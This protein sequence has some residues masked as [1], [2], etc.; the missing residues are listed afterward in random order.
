M[1]ETDW[2]R[3]WIIRLIDMLQQR[4]RGQQV[5]V[6]GDLL[7]Y[8]EEGNPKR[9]L[10]PD[11]FVVL[12]HQPGMRRIYKLWEEGKSPNA[13]IE[14]TSRRTKREDANAKPQK[15][16]AIGVGEYFLFDPTNDYLR[17][18][19]RGYRLT[20][21]GY[22]PIEPDATGGLI[23]EQLS[24]RLCLEAGV[25]VVRDLATGEPLLT[26]AGAERAALEAKD[27]VLEAE[28]AALQR[29]RASLRQERAAREAAEAELQRLRKQLGERGSS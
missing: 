22:V 3:D 15:Y 4:Y 26:E 28:R 19:L 13:V 1:G 7:L 18:P 16:A 9:F 10:V 17:P 23:C 24:L 20:D 25:L 21:E 27:A 29:E 12:N 6:T 5:Y 8:Y 2:H 11:V 14:V